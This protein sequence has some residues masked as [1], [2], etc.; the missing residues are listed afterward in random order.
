MMILQMKQKTRFQK[1]GPYTL[2]TCNC[3]V[4]LLSYMNCI[5]PSQ[6]YNYIGSI[7]QPCAGSGCHDNQAWGLSDLFTILWF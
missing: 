7:V 3:L 2:S 1:I 4:P 5:L 6:D